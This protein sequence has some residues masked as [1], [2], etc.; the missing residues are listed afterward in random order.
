MLRD[1]ANKGGT[2]YQI[3][4]NNIDEVLPLINYC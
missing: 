3:D 4:K 1:V 2:I